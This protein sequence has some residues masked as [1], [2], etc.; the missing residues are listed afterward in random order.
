MQ[1]QAQFN[2][3]H[4]RSLTPPDMPERSEDDIKEA[5]D[6]LEDAILNK[7]LIWDEDNDYRVNYALEIER[8]LLNEPKDEQLAL[9]RD[10]FYKNVH[11]YCVS[12]VKRDPAYYCAEY[13]E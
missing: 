4:D 3:A 6:A 10:A 12:V 11:D 9:I 13:C 7:N 5:I 2:L 1:T 8:I